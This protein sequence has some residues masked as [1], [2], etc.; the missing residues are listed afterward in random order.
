MRGG[1]A[2]SFRGIPESTSPVASR[3]ARASPRRSHIAGRRETLRPYRPRAPRVKVRKVSPPSK[4]TLALR[5]E[6][7]R[8][9]GWDARPILLLPGETLKVKDEDRARAYLVGFE[10]GQSEGATVEGVLEEALSKIRRGWTRG[11]RWECAGCH[12]LVDMGACWSCKTEYPKP[13]FADRKPVPPG[14]KEPPRPVRVDVCEACRKVL[15]GSDCP[16]CDG[17]LSNRVW[18]DAEDE[19]GDPIFG[20]SSGPRVTLDAALG[21]SLTLD[22]PRSQAISRARTLVETVVLEW[23]QWGASQKGESPPDHVDLSYWNAKPW[24]R[25]RAVEYLLTLALERCDE[26]RA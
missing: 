13:V 14:E 24:R 21:S 25:Q 20:A 2:R 4:L 9:V 15:R 12:V 16:F 10:I 8:R 5:E 23:L 1:C 26:L 6:R 18:F 17:V 19:E 3:R 7:A 22:V 11:V